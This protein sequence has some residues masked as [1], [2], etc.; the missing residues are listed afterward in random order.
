MS[1]ISVIVGN[2][3]PQSRTREIAEE[4][5]VRVA[6]RTNASVLPT[7]DLIDHAEQLF[8]WP[9]ERVDALIAELANSDYAIIASPTYKASYTGLLKAFLDRYPANGLAG[10]TTIPVFTIGSDEHALAVEFTLRPLLV[11]LGASVPTRGLSFVTPRFDR[12]SEVIDDW[13]A[14]EAQALWPERRAQEL[15]SAALDPQGKKG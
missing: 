5:A 12:R 14:R 11:E 10:V 2:P 8:A 3:K 6:A 9:S 7:I 13:L 1:T 15:D 4:L